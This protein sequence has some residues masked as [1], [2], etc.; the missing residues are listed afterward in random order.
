[1]GT[2]IELELSRSNSRPLETSEFNLE[3]CE[4]VAFPA[5][6]HWRGA[7]CCAH[8]TGHLP[9]GSPLWFSAG[10]GGHAAAGSKR[11]LTQDPN[12]QIWNQLT[13]RCTYQ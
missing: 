7:A 4:A 6:D 1:V 11:I 12:R 8:G 5:G 3:S 9:S 13:N 2:R 10:N